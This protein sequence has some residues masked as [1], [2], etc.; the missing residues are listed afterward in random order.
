MPLINKCKNFKDESLSRAKVLAWHALIQNVG[1]KIKDYQPKI[2]FPF[3]NFC[4]G[5]DTSGEIKV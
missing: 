5:I 3:F 1:D 4:F 2:L